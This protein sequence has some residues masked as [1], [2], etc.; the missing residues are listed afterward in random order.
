MICQQLLVPLESATVNLNATGVGPPVAMAL[1]REKRFETC[2]WVLLILV[3]LY[4]ALRVIRDLNSHVDLFAS[5]TMAPTGVSCVLLIVC[6]GFQICSALALIWPRLS[7]IRNGKLVALA[8][9]CAAFTLQLVVSFASKTGRTRAVVLVAAS[10]LQFVREGSSRSGSHMGVDV[11]QRICDRVYGR[12]REAATRYKSAAVCTFLMVCY[13]GVY[14]YYG[15]KIVFARH[16]IQRE[17]GVEQ[18]LDMFGV[19]TFLFSVGSFQQNQ[20]IMFTPLDLDDDEPVGRVTK[21][22]RTLERLAARAWEG[23]GARKSFKDL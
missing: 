11:E 13:F 12:V 20:R 7:T 21:A 22:K 10:F 4:T 18:F 16:K 6:S 5:T 19:F 14:L 2:S 15:E 17:I 23:R 1:S 3:S 8:I 9:L